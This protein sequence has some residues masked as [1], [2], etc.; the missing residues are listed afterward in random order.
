M[1]YP[2]AWLCAVCEW[3]HGE[4]VDGELPLPRVD[5]VYY[6]RFDD[7]VKIGTTS[8]PRQ[9]LGAIWHDD[10]L[11][12]ERGD[13]RL[14]RRRHEEFADERF[15]RTEW[16]RFSERLREHIEAVRGGGAEEPWDRYTRWISETVALRG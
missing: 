14:E 15:D 13:R 11:A 8:N 4:L 7:R 10:L 9:R 5:V 3:V 6:L 12:F 16:F 2:S 1:R